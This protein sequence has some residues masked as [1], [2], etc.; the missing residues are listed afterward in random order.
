M[1]GKAMAHAGS[2]DGLLGAF[3]SKR[4]LWSRALRVEYK[5][6]QD[7]SLLPNLHFASRN[8]MIRAPKLS[9]QFST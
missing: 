5:R 9:E 4:Y 8:S 3:W 1:S 6:L 7:H 2:L